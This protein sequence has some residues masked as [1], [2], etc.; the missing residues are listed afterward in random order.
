ML[1]EEHA[2]GACLCRVRT[3][4]C[5]SFNGTLRGL[6]LATV[7]AGGTAAS[8]ALYTPPA[9]VLV[10]ALAGVGIATRTAWQ[11]TR[12]NAV[13]DRALTHVTTA[14]GLIRL[15]LSP[16]AAPTPPTTESPVPDL[17]NEWPRS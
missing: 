13:L 16:E 12:A 15:P 7:L 17:G 1:V 9:G 8:L 2:G 5:P 10:A 14:A 11:T 6:A 4:L 3:R